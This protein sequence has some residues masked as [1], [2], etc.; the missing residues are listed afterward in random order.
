[1]V[2]KLRELLEVEDNGVGVAGLFDIL[3]G[4]LASAA[5]MTDRLASKDDTKDRQIREMK[6]EIAGLR[7]AINGSRGEMELADLSSGVSATDEGYARCLHRLDRMTRKYAAVKEEAAQLVLE[8]ADRD[9]LIASLRKLRPVTTRDD[10]ESFRRE[11]DQQSAALQS[12]TSFVESV[13]E[14]VTEFHG[15]VMETFERSAVYS[16]LVLEILR[17]A[18]PIFQAFSLPVFLVDFLRRPVL[19][20][21]SYRIVSVRPSVEN[22]LFGTVHRQILR[23]ISRELA[24]FPVAPRKLSVTTGESLETKLQNILRLLRLVRDLFTE[25]EDS[26]RQLSSVVRSQHAAI[27][28]MTHP[29]PHSPRAS[30]SP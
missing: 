4:H 6:D 28:D 26:L 8:L 15:F 25:K 7:R 27:L 1:L 16:P 23:D 10:R 22:E 29:A 5:R 24:A 2:A 13:T 19:V 17:S 30:R 20:T 12:T 11:L 14:V 9:K 18:K 3:Q 21:M